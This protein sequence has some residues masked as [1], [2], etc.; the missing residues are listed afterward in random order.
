M[1][2]FCHT[3]IYNL[4]TTCFQNNKIDTHKKVPAM[5]WKKSNILYNVV[6]L[7]IRWSVEKF[8]AYEIVWNI[9]W[10]NSHEVNWHHQL[11]LNIH[12]NG[13]FS[14]LIQQR[15]KSVWCVCV[16]AHFGLF[17]YRFVDNWVSFWIFKDKKK[18]PQQNCVRANTTLL[19]Q[20]INFGIYFIWFPYIWDAIE[21]QQIFCLKNYVSFTN[22]C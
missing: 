2:D 7:S 3:Y 22:F 9:Y 20:C 4:C 10:M 5:S 21:W 16:C 12:E 17:I 14:T 8:Q 1:C 18:D 19:V 11:V 13:K 6:T 15:E